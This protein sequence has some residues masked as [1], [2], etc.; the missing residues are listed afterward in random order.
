VPT[1]AGTTRR[2][3]ELIQVQR[4]KGRYA[5]VFF[6][7]NQV[8]ATCELVRSHLRSSRYITCP[9]RAHAMTQPAK[10]IPRWLTIDLLVIVISLAIIGIGI[11]IGI[12]P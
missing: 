11:G 7:I 8:A 6:R 2:I 4:G 5:L 3:C 12:A 1:M 9:R 10:R